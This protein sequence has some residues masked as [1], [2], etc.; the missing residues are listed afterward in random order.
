MPG[1]TYSTFVTAIA[2]EMVVGP[3]D[4][5]FLAILPTL[6]DDSE[7]RIYRELD[8]LT[9]VVT[10]NGTATAN[11]RTFTL[12]TSGSMGTIHFLVIDA[13]NVLDATSIRHPVKPATREG[14]DFLYPGENSLST[15]CYPGVFCR[16]DDLSIIYGPAPDSTYTVEVIGT[17][18]PAPLS[19]TNTST[20]LSLYLSD[21]FL[22]GAMVS[23]SG[24]M[25]NFGSQGDDP[26]M[27]VSWESQFQTRLAS[28]KKEELRKSYIA[29]MSTPPSS[30]KDA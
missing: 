16:A 3:T 26:R 25:R 11:S 8:L 10:V 12:P 20:Y 19:A 29:A 22:A 14:V 28:A 30:M 15:P 1:Y 18:R 17:I 6:I 23:A 7:Q 2:A 24:Y 9:S 4:S 5:D 27:S 21:L 13:I